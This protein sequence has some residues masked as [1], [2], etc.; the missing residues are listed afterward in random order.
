[1]N[2]F[3]R[4][5]RIDIVDEGL[6]KFAEE[7]QEMVRVKAMENLKNADSFVVVS[8]NRENHNVEVRSSVNGS[9]SPIIVEILITITK[10]V[11]DEIV[12]SGNFGLRLEL[13]KVLNK[14]KP[15]SDD[16]KGDG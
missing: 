3:K 9:E 15:T 10:Q 7:T 13:A 11:M 8:L 6:K 14:A 4:V 5:E 1:M 2:D 12:N 16:A